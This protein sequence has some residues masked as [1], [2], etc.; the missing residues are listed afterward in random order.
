[1]FPNDNI[2]PCVNA[3]PP[4]H[5]HARPKRL[6]ADN[7]MNPAIPSLHVQFDRLCGQMLAAETTPYLRVMLKIILVFQHLPKWLLGIVVYPNW[8][9]FHGSLIKDWGWV[10]TLVP[11]IGTIEWIRSLKTRWECMRGDEGGRVGDSFCTPQQ[12]RVYSTFHPPL[13]RDLFHILRQT[14]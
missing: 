3:P 1:M 12:Q 4:L 10:K 8:S 5:F 14:L 13:P 11:V 2:I 7:I 6:T 9:L